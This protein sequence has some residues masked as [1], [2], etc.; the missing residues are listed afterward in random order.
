MALGNGTELTWY[1]HATWLL[2]TPDG[3]RI[4]ID[5][6]K[7][8]N[9]AWPAE[10]DDPGDIDALLLTHAH[11]NHMADAIPMAAAGKPDGYR[12]HDRDRRLPGEEGRREHH[13]DEQGR[14]G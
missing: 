1:G 7:T 8:G 6:W 12:L 13:R 11:S 3:K 2:V 5:P 4:L 9:P 14:L 10:L